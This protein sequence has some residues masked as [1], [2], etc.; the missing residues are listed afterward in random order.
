MTQKCSSL[1]W[2]HISCPLHQTL[3]PPLPVHLQDLNL[4]WEMKGVHSA[5]AIRLTGALDHS[6]AP[7]PM[8][9]PCQGPV[10]LVSLGLAPLLYL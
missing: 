1:Q 8:H 4:T 10:S 3:T 9:L 7:V 6:L 2:S 5:I